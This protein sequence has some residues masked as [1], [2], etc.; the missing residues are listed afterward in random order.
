MYALDTNTLVHAFQGKGGVLERLLAV[1]PAEVALPAVA[2]YELEVGI[3][4]STA[5]PHRRNQ[6]HALALFLRVL[7]FG[8]GEARAAARI[9][10]E[11]E[12]AGQTIGPLDLLI[13]GTALQHGATLVTHNVGEFS[14]IAGLQIEDWF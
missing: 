14:R 12:K 1:P 2:L 13:A 5:A 7:P 4:R 11:L 3:A 10:V 6:L 8:T 9:R